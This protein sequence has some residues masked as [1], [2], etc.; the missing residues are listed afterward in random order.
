M[1]YFNRFFGTLNSTTKSTH[2]LLKSDGFYTRLQPSKKKENIVSFIVEPQCFVNFS[3]TYLKFRLK[4]II[5]DEFV[6]VESFVDEVTVST[7]SIFNSTSNDKLVQKFSGISLENSRLGNK[8]LFF[9]DDEVMILLPILTDR[10]RIMKEECVKISVKFCNSISEPEIFYEKTKN[11]TNLN[12][13]ITD[14]LIQS[15][16]LK[17]EKVY[18]F[19]RVKL[20]KDY[21]REFFV[22]IKQNKKFIKAIKLDLVINDQVVKTI[23]GLQSRQ[24]IPALHYDI[25]DNPD[26]THFFDLESYESESDRYVVNIDTYNAKNTYL[27]IYLPAGIY[28]LC[29]TYNTSVVFEFSSEDAINSHP[30]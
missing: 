21:I 19:C 22:T 7:S 11:K 14:E 26:L 23:S 10:F 29:I 4:D 8:I 9:E 13:K 1:S 18:N 12:Y 16:D 15:I 6:R 2:N 27:D 28:D 5:V 30:I 3:F 24:I 20:S 17:D 25:F